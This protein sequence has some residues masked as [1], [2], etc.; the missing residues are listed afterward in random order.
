[1]SVCMVFLHEWGS[2]VL[3]VHGAYRLVSGCLSGGHW[4]PASSGPS[5]TASLLWLSLS[6]PVPADIPGRVRV[7]QRPLADSARHRLCHRIYF[8]SS[9]RRAISASFWRHSATFSRS[10]PGGSGGAVPPLAFE[11]SSC[12]RR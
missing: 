12:A 8:E 11:P 4:S 3:A 7:D 9:D 10:A 1:M 6:T 5:G 2:L